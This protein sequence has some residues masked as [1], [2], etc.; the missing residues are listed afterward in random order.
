MQSQYLQ[1][2]YNKALDKSYELCL[3][4]DSARDSEN[5]VVLYINIILFTYTLRISFLIRIYSRMMYRQFYF[6]LYWCSSVA[7][8]NCFIKK[9]EIKY[10]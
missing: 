9:L 3:L 8:V 6:S 5:K 2:N 4:V 1:K 10:I 7:N